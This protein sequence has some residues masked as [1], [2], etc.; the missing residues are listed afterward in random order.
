MR[1]SH[2]GYSLVHC[3]ATKKMLLRFFN[4]T[5]KCKMTPIVSS[6][7]N[8]GSLDNLCV[9]SRMERMPVLIRECVDF[10]W[11][12]SLVVLQQRLPKGSSAP[13]ASCPKRPIQITSVWI[14][15]KLQSS[16]S[17]KPCLFFVCL[18]G[19]CVQRTIEKQMCQ[20]HVLF[21]INKFEGRAVFENTSPIVEIMSHCFSAG[22]GVLRGPVVSTCCCVSLHVSRIHSEDRTV[23]QHC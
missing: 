16:D 19:F 10:S 5:D 23:H 18:F 6:V 17:F 21:G 13:F 2:D 9:F 12:A 14:A 7:A 20:K 22:F 1:M 3:W 8:H 11:L 15:R 4:N